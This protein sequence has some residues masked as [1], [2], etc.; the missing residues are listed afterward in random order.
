MSY[1]NFEKSELINL[2]YSLG[3]E[4]LRSNRAGSYASTTI[5]AC[6]TRKYHGLLVCPMEHLDGDK[7]VLLS[8]FDCTVVQSGSEF[9]MGIHKYKGDLY[10]PK[11]HKYVQDFQADSVL[12]IYYRVGGV[13]IL[14]ESVLV[15]KQQQMLIKYTLLEA[16][17]TTKLKFTPFLAFRNIHQ[18]SKANMHAQ[19]KVKYIKNG[20]K[21]KL[22]DGYPFLHMQFSKDVEFVPTPDWYYNIEYIE[23]QRRGYDYKEDLFVP[24][25]FEVHIRKGESVIFSASTTETNPSTL[26]RKYSAEL[27]KR[28]VRDSFKSC[29]INSAQQ[30]IVRNE[31]KTQIIAG[32]PWFGNWGRDTFI[33][34]P[35]LTLTQGDKK[36][37]KSVIDGMIAEL[38]HGLFPNRGPEDDLIYNSVDTSLWFFWSLQQYCIKYPHDCSYIWKNYSKAIKSILKSLKEG[39]IHNIKMLDNGLI[40]AGEKGMALTWMDAVVDGKPVTPRTGCAVEVN[41]LWY[42]AIMF[43]MKLAEKAGDDAFVKKWKTL[44]EKIVKSFTSTFWDK[45]KGYLADCADGEQKDW[46]VRPN[47]VIA[48][49]VQFSPIKDEI[50]QAVLDVVKR[51]LLTSRGLRTLAPN[52][53]DYNGKYEGWQELR[54]LAYHQGTVWPWLI[55]HFCTGYINLYKKSGLALLKRIVKDFE[56]TMSEHGIGSISEIY[57]GDPPHKPRGAISQAWSVSALLRVIEMIDEIETQTNQ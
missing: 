40:Y 56:P 22:Y 33:S 16:D 21:A 57:D 28:V 46:S 47:Q 38:K 18:L 7:H 44:P 20:V 11:G 45:N 26:K 51:D 2:E 6:N 54:D 8:T 27:E 19:T 49:S 13:R 9:N 37:F 29:L 42:N 55:E 53:P 36:T 4:M 39:T 12:Q 43:S 15:E 41:A 1:L 32:F 23:E 17:K 3:R 48:A 10:H 35:G 50:K 31:K 30:F 5:I 24:G 14:R 34:L 52:H 25:F